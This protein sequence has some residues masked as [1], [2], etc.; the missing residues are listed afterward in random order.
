MKV[1]ITKEE[2]SEYHACKVSKGY[3]PVDEGRLKEKEV[4]LAAVG[5]RCG[6]IFIGKNG[7]LPDAFRQWSEH[8][9]QYKNYNFIEDDVLRQI[10]EAYEIMQ[11]SSWWDVELVDGK[12]TVITKEVKDD[13]K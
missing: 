13:T 6:K 4:P 7:Y 9:S 8:C 10:S 3:K 5:C 11:E 1:E 2:F 12:P